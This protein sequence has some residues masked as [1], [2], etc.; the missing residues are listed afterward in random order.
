MEIRFRALTSKFD[1]SEFLNTVR[2]TTTDLQIGDVA[3]LN[4]YRTTRSVGAVAVSGATLLKGASGI[5]ALVTGYANTPKSVEETEGVADEAEIGRM[6]E[7][8]ALKRRD[9]VDAGRGWQT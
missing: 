5:G 1:A 6:L 8:G 2:D 7:A 3:S 9:L 4:R